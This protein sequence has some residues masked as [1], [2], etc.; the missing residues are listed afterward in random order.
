LIQIELRNF[1]SPDRVADD[2]QNPGA[3]R[4]TGAGRPTLPLSDEQ[5][6]RLGPIFAE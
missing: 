3:T 5:F 1:G 6:S 2:P 4:R